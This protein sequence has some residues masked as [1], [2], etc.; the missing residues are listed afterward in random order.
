MSYGTKYFLK[1]FP[2]KHWLLSGF[3]YQSVQKGL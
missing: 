1:E 3:P 2:T